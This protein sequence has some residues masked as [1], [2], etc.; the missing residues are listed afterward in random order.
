MDVTVVTVTFVNMTLPE[1]CERLVVMQLIEPTPQVTVAPL[2][3]QAEQATADVPIDA[4]PPERVNVLLAVSV[5][6][7]TVSEPLETENVVQFTVA[8]DHVTVAL[9]MAIPP[10]V[11]NPVVPKATV[12]LV[13]RVIV[14]VPPVTVKLVN[15]DAPVPLIVKEPTVNAEFPR[16]VI[17]ADSE[18]DP[19]VVTALSFVF[20][21]PLLCVNVVPLIASLNFQEPPEPLKVIA[22]VVLPPKSN[23]S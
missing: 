5:R 15:V 18:N 7:V 10:F 23:V 6:L 2:S 22:A 9:L 20:T 11:V 21:V 16:V 8:V 12:P 1:L 3:V 13:D 19:V 14:P 4:V 17:P